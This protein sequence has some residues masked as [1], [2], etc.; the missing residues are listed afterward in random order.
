[1]V[2]KFAQPKLRGSSTFITNSCEPAAFSTQR[3]EHRTAVGI[4]LLISGNQDGGIAINDGIYGHD[5]GSQNTWGAAT[6]INLPPA[7]EVTQPQK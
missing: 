3:T 5:A 1:M 7:L 2:Y 6:L 4:P